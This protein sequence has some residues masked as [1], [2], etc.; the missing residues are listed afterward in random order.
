[1]VYYLRRSLF[2][3][4]PIFCFQAVNVTTVI[5]CH[6]LSPFLCLTFLIS[7]NSHTLRSRSYWWEK[8]DMERLSNLSKVT[9]CYWRSQD[10]VQ[11]WS[12]CLNITLFLFNKTFISWKLPII[13]YCLLTTRSQMPWGF[14][15]AFPR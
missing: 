11:L 12:Q 2:L 13:T 3:S 4:H 9:G 7:F 5:F 15:F 10:I 6:F 8:W 1:M 14:I